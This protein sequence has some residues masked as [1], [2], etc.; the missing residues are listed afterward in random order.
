MFVVPVRQEEASLAIGVGKG[1][2]FPAEEITHG[3]FV[4]NIGNT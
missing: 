1:V 2:V 4:G 3:Q